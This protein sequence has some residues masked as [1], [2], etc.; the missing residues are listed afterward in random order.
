M[1]E[2]GGKRQNAGRK[3]KGEEQKL[4]ENLT[5]MNPI[6]LKALKTG[7]SNDES[8]AIKLFFEYFYGKPQQRID[9]TSGDEPMNIP[10]ISYFDTK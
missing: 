6:A 5:P 8:W 1:A 7:L 9:V 10:A 4:I 3:S 2:H